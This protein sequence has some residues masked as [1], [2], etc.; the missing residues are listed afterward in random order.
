MC[1]FL[2]DFGHP[3]THLQ[4]CQISYW[5]WWKYRVGKLLKL[6]FGNVWPERY[7]AVYFHISSAEHSVTIFW[8]KT[9]PERWIIRAGNKCSS[10]KRIVSVSHD[11]LTPLF[12]DT[13]DTMWI[14]WK[15][16]KKP[17]PNPGGFNFDYNRIVTISLT[18]MQTIDAIWFEDCILWHQSICPNKR[19]VTSWD[20]WRPREQRILAMYSKSW[21]I[22]WMIDDCMLDSWTFAIFVSSITNRITPW[23]LLAI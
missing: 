12:V 13:D 18:T 3:N 23:K 5:F 8:A 22:F 17:R 21:V 15:K 2:R 7:S 4:F 16:Q 9:L 1:C 11:Q 20:S 14:R 6:R 10:Q 19:N